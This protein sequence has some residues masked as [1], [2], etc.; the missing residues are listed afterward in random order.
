MNKKYVIVLFAL[1]IVSNAIAQNKLF[2]GN[3]LLMP[4]NLIVNYVVRMD[5]C[6]KIINNH[7]SDSISKAY[8]SNHTEKD[9]FTII[10]EN[11]FSGRIN[12]YQSDS[13][14]SY[15]LM[16]NKK[17]ISPTK[18]KEGLGETNDHSLNHHELIGLNFIE[19][20]RVTNNPL[21]FEKKIIAYMPIR[22][23]FSDNDTTL[24]NPLYKTPFTIFDSLPQKSM[25]RKSNRRMQLTNEIAYEYFFYMDYTSPYDIDELMKI[26]NRSKQSLG[27]QIL[28]KETSEYLSVSGIVNFL[29]VLVNKIINGDL[30]AYNY[31]DNQPMKVKEV[32]EEMGSYKM[33]VE[34]DGVSEHSLIEYTTPME[35]DEIQSIIFLEKWY[36]DPLT[37]RMQKKVVGVAPVRFYYKDD[38]EYEENLIRKVLFKVYFNEKDKF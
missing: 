35:F 28:N 4:S 27:D 3:N 33:L 12:F 15:Q 29:K 32:E 6:Y 9:L 8:L 14:V 37:L 10:L 1:F 2:K 21:A 23:Y 17:L 22:R 20:W 19:E 5:T 31:Y 36:M 16:E 24:Q 30:K 7:C 34:D 13:W 11:A 18:A 26:Y 25:I 38:D